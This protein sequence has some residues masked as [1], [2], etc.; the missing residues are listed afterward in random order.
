MVWSQG[1]LLSQFETTF[2]AEEL[3]GGHH[4]HEADDD[5][6]LSFSKDKRSPLYNL[7]VIHH[8]TKG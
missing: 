8:F 3:A 6:C 5:L 4:H 1:P 7:Q 2:V